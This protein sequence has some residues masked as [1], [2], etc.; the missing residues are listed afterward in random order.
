MQDALIFQPIFKT[1]MEGRPELARRGGSR[2]AFMRSGRNRSL[3]FIDYSLYEI[4]NGMGESVF[5]TDDVTGWPPFVDVGMG[6]FR[7]D[8]VAE[9]L[10]I[11]RVVRAEKFQPIHFF[12]IEKQR[13]GAAVDFESNGV[14]AAACQP[15]GFE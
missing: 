9:T 7:Y 6:W 12:E 3:H 1:R 4:G 5:V 2:T 14:L 15:G 8:N 13:A 11:L 10:S